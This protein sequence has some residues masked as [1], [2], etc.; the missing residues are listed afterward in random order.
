MNSNSDK[1]DSRDCKLMFVIVL[2]L[3]EE[4]KEVMNFGNK[5]NK[6]GKNRR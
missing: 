4:I 3:Q 2:E 1:K 5:Y 6:N